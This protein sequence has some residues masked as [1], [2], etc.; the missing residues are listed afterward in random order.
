MCIIL[1]IEVQSLKDPKVLQDWLQKQ[2]VD[3]GIKVTNLTTSW[4]DGMAL[5]A[6]IHHYH[7]ELMWVLHTILSVSVSVV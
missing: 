7:P 4:S 6:V 1:Y 5:C 2:V 3:Y